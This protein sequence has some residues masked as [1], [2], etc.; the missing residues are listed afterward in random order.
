MMLTEHGDLEDATLKLIDFGL[1]RRFEA[2]APM[3]T[4]ACTPQYVAPEVLS[5]AYTE[6]CD[7]WSVGVVLYVLLCGSPP[8]HGDSDAQVFA[9]VRSGLLDFGPAAWERVGA[10]ARELVRRLL[11]VDA[12]ARPT[13][14]QLLLE[15][16]VALR[17]TRPWAAGQPGWGAEPPRG[18]NLSRALRGG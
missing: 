8:F 6:A 16:W 17:P 15:P 18:A 4:L 7:L 2:G 10:P 9:R 3:R 12:G 13:A 1:S 14:A 11:Q 5:G